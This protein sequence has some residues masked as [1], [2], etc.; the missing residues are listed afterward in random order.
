[1]EILPLKDKMESE[2]NPQIILNQ[3]WSFD[4]MNDVTKGKEGSKNAPLN[5]S[6]GAKIDPNILFRK[7]SG[8]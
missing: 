5:H 6:L 2:K 1:M 3:V 7:F 8:F 4:V